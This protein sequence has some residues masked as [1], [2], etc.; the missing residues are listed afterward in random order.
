M[1]E[2]GVF[3]RYSSS[4]SCQRGTGVSYPGSSITDVRIVPCPKAK[5][6]IPEVVPSGSMGTAAASTATATAGSSAAAPSRRRSSPWGLGQSRS[7]SPGCAAAA[8][9]GAVLLRDFAPH[10]RKIRGVEEL[11]PWLYFQG[12]HQPAQLALVSGRMK[13]RPSTLE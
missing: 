1:K 6:V 9:V 7:G 2:G 10:R 11:F 5:D 4:P 13:R 8:P 3:L 12:Q